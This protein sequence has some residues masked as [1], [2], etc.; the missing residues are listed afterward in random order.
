MKLYNQE[1]ELLIL[2]SI[3]D[4]DNKVKNK[5]LANTSE[6]H[7][8]SDFTRE[9]FNRISAQV[10]NDSE[11]PSFNELL[12]DP[13]LS[14]D[15]RKQLKKLS[16]DLTPIKEKKFLRRLK[17]LHQYRQIRDLYFLSEN[18]NNELQK[19]KVKIGDILENAAETLSRARA[20]VNTKNE[21]HHLGKSNN[22]SPVIKRLLDKSPPNLVPTGFS[23]WDNRN[24]GMAYGSLIGIGGPAGG[25]KTAL[26]L[27]LALN[28]SE[29]GKEDVAYVPLEMDEEETLE[30]I[31]S[32]KSG[33]PLY[34]IK[35][36]KTNQA[37]DDAIIDAYNKYV[38][39]LKKDDTR[40]TIFAP[41]SDVSI[42]EVLLTLKP[43]GHRVII[44]DYLTLLKG[45]GSD[46]SVEKQWQKIGD[47]GRRAKIWAKS[48]NT[49]VILVAQIDDEGKLRYSRA[50]KEHANVLWTWPVNK[51]TR[52]NKVM[53]ISSEKARNMTLID[54][55]LSYDDELFQVFDNNS[56]RAR[57]KSEDTD[58]NEHAKDDYL[59]NVE[60]D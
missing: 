1:L 51:E 43:Y 20:N 24:G 7:F 26:A 60:E 49:I 57:N 10:R 25:G 52:E 32:N 40:L 53:K 47:I 39:Q 45:T 9:T 35:Q 55:E 14:E 54:F 41:E 46:D 37:E 15:T 42:E 22:V 59:A 36:R 2:F 11:I 31:I 21:V 28:M 33:V 29:I 27:Q 4:A 23:A 16:R 30:R 13:V 56:E 50:L 38:K 58:D 44:I 5:L 19:E 17:Q 34:K 18:I 12:V 6:S 3:C 8:Y 48:N